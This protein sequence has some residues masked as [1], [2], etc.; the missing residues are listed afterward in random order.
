MDADD[1]RAMRAPLDDMDVKLR[2]IL[3]TVRSIA[4]VGASPKSERPSHE[5]MRFLQSKGYRVHPVNPGIAGQVLLGERVHAMLKDIP[6]PV[7]MVDLF[8]ASA[9]IPPFVDDAIDI[10]AKVVWMQLGVRHEAAAARAEAAGLDVVM[11]RCP[12]IEFVRL[13]LP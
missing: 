11:D 8:R 9:S 1:L 5:V 6:E 4:L 10:G 3:S 12:K 13:G 7:D 2:R